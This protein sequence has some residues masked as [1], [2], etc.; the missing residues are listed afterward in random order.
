MMR[1]ILLPV[2]FIILPFGMINM[3]PRAANQEV[4]G[5]TYC[6]I[7]HDHSPFSSRMIQKISASQYFSLT[8]NVSTYGEALHEMEAGN[9]DFIVEIEP[10]FERSLIKEGIAKVMIS[11][12][13]VNGVKGGL[14]QSYLIQIIADFAAPLREEEGLN[15][16]TVQIPRIEASPRYLFNTQ[17]Y[18]KVFMVPGLMAMLLILMVGFLPALNIVGEKEK[19]TIEQINVTPIGRFEF[20]FSKLIP[21]WVLGLFIMGY[22]MLLAKGI[23]GLVPVGNIG[24]LM[25]FSSLF[26]LVVSSFG[27]LVSNYSET[28]QQA[29]LM[30]LFF[31]IIFILTSGLITP[32]SSMPPWAQTLTY[33]NPL[34]YFIEVLRAIYLKGSGFT[35][36]VSQFVALCV[37]ASVIWIWAIRSYRK[38]G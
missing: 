20:I 11:A 19:G 18:Y 6:V 9:A 14:G 13:A 38:N 15:R 3:M 33:L 21:Y 27:L 2:L 36:L 4:K 22:S 23:Y 10:D 28:T 26:I 37:Y 30:M 7:D 5:L 16:H 1:N 24:L 34:R 31:L 12:N 8:G 25:L 17:L 32:I 29:A 35:D